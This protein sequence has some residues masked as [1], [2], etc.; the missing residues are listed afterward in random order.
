MTQKKKSKAG[1]KKSVEP[2]G[3]MTPT[4]LSVR[5]VE[6]FEGKAK[7]VG[8]ELSQFIRVALYEK[9]VADEFGNKNKGKG[10]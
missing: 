10:V 5:E 4:Y 7:E 9:V 3:I 6:A 8:L 1:R 2:R